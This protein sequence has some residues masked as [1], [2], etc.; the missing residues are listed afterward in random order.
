MIAPRGRTDESD[1]F[2]PSRGVHPGED[3]FSTS[4][5][6]LRPCFPGFVVFF[7]DMLLLFYCSTHDATWDRWTVGVDRWGP[8]GP[9]GG[10][11]WGSPGPGH[12]A[13]G[14]PG[15]AGGRRGSPGPGHCAGGTSI[16]HSRLRRASGGFRSYRA[17]ILRR[18]SCR[19]QELP[20]GSTCYILRLSSCTEAS[21]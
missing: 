3:P 18:K 5:F 6:C 8:L 9:L 19:S 2:L 15:V 12:C 4:R 13:V 20:N 16:F 17:R 10:D 7:F 21:L 14:S 11:R 1:F